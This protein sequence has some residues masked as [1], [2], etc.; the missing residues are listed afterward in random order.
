M[1]KKLT[2]D[3]RRLLLIEEKG[4]SAEVQDALTFLTSA[5]IKDMQSSGRHNQKQSVYWNNFNVTLF[6]DLDLTVDYYINIFAKPTTQEQKKEFKYNRSKHVISINYVIYL[7][8][9][10]PASIDLSICPMFLTQLSHELKHA[11]QHYMVNRN[12]GKDNADLLNYKEDIIYNAALNVTNSQ[13]QK[14]TLDK[15]IALLIYYTNDSEITAYQEALYTGG[16]KV[17]YCDIE[18]YVNNSEVAGVS[19]KIE[20][21][22]H[23]IQNKNVNPGSPL[24]KHLKY[25]YNRDLNWFIRRLNNGLRKYKKV[26]KDTEKMLKKRNSQTMREGFQPDYWKEIMESLNLLL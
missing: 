12:R 25:V 16:Q 1:L 9:F 13:T 20:E 18:K 11:Y 3:T 19:N 4:I 8:E 23:V 6:G 21:M 10:N 14:G 7:P 5:L 15:L 17:E 22:L 2:E 26:L 24:D